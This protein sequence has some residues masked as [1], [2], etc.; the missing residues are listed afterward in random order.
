ME[1]INFKKFIPYLL[2]LLAFVLIS[3]IYFSPALEGKRLKQGDIDRFKGM[4]KEITDFRETTGE[5]TLWTNNMFSGMPAYFISVAF[6]G[7][8]MKK[9]LKFMELGLPHPANQL[10]L[11]FIGFFILLLV[12]RLKPWTAAIGAFAFAFSSYFFIILEAGHNSKAGAISFMAPVLAG[13]ILTYRGK[14]MAGALLTAFFLAL[15]IATNHLQITYYLLLIVLVYGIYELVET[16]RNKTYSNF[17]KATA[18][19]VVAA[20]I[21]VGT[22]ATSLLISADHTQY[23]T[24]GKSELTFDKSNKTTGLER[25]YITQWSY[26]ITE[27]MTLLVPDF[28][29]GASYGEV[30]ENSNTYDFFISQRLPRSAAKQLTQQLPLYWGNQPF[31]SGPVYVGAIIFFLFVFG[32]IVVKGKYKWWLLTVTVLALM[33]SWGKNMMWFTNI[34]LDYLPGY[35]KFRAV[36]MTLVI[37]ELSIPL[38]GFIALSKVFN[39]ERDDALMMKGLKYTTAILGGVLLIIIAVPGMLFSFNGLGDQ[40]YLQNLVNAGLPENL[41]NGLLNAIIDD[42]I[43]ILRIDA[44]RSLVFILLSAGLLW[45]YLKKKIKLA[46]AIAGLGLLIVIDMW[47]VNKRYLNNDNFERQSVVENPYKPS[48]ADQ[49]IMRD[50][51]LGF[52]VLNLTVDPFRDASTSYFHHSIGGYHGAKLERYQELIDFQLGPEVN[53]L[54]TV[55]RSET[56]LNKIQQMMS[57]LNVLNMLNTKY[58]IIMGNQGPVPVPND[59]RLGPAWFVSHYEIMENADEEI[60]T[61]GDIDPS[62]TLILDKRYASY[63]EGKS[64]TPDSSASIELVDYEPN[65]LTYKTRSG[66]EQLAVFSEVYYP[67]GWTAYID[68]KE[69]PHFRADWILR[70]MVVPSGEHTIEFKFQ[71][72]IYATG[73][74]ISLAS[75]ILLLL[76]VVVYAVVE[77]RKKL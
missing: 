27:S 48:S 73:E 18:Y 26:G 77:V 12:L 4:S 42:R 56:D 13:I 52:R 22:H 36:S 70:A 67:N 33:L 54:L 38:L 10:F 17:I 2:A 39:K 41:K 34:F 65:H 20:L 55:L 3:L 31:T 29:G 46:Y 45:L 51:E 16:I 11:Y 24:R 58:F 35:N 1:K 63:L 15:E 47:A 72:A 57:G 7:N 75:S 40:E 76:L 6:E 61:V 53:R 59:Y 28:M 44:F 43:R 66:S 49:E 74:T 9:V 5:Q 23:T 64:F 32:L 30:G 68:G 14:Y 37:A 21:A 69:V 62:Q 50:Q 19:L 60:T 71:P 25:D 8:L